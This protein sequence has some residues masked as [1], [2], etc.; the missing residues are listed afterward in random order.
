MAEILA[1][2]QDTGLLGVGLILRMTP[3][4]AREFAKLVSRKADEAEAE[5]SR[6]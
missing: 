3:T 2:E 5:L 1:P 6:G 4:E